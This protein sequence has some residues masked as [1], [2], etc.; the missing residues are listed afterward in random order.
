SRP[1]LR[2]SIPQQQP[3]SG[4]P[5]RRKQ[6]PG[7]RRS[8]PRLI[9]GEGALEIEW[10]TVQPALAQFDAALEQCGVLTFCLDTFGQDAAAQRLQL[11]CCLFDRVDERVTAV[12]VADHRD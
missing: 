1:M 12:G 2:F 10:A 3:A 9:A 4:W 5:G 8:W 7:C 6:A 11:G